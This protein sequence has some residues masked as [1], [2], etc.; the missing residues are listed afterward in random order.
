MV[1]AK[2]RAASPEWA[3]AALRRSPTACTT[4]RPSRR[5]A[6]STSTGSLRTGEQ[7]TALAESNER[8]G[9]ST[10]ASTARRATAMLM[11]PKA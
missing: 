8:S 10:A 3:S 9:R 2:W 6:V 11:P 5:T 1:A 7:N 4:D